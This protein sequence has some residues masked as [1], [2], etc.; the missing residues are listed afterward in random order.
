MELVTWNL[1]EGEMTP[2]RVKNYIATNNPPAARPTSGPPAL[3]GMKI[4]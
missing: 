1:E 3:R 4:Y 2:R